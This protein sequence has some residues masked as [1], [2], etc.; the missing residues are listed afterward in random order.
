MQI[1]TQQINLF[2]LLILKGNTTELKVEYK[3]KGGDL[4]GSYS[5]R[6]SQRQQ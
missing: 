6:K 4:D 3:Q 2:N 5:Q 1:T